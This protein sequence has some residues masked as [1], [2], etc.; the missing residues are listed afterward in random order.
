MKR[1]EPGKRMGWKMGWKP[2]SHWLILLLFTDLFFVFQAWL[3]RPEAFKSTVIMIVLFTVLI[4]LAGVLIDRRRQERQIRALRS[5]LSQPR[6]E[7][8][9]RLLEATD[10]SWHPVIKLVAAQIREQGRMI[11]DKQGELQNYREFIEAW[12]HEIKTPLSLATLVLNNRREEMSPYVHKRMEHVR[13]TISSYVDRILYY[14]RLQSDHADYKF[15]Q[16]DL[17]AFV[18][19]ALEDFRPIADEKN[20]DVQLELPPLQVISDKKVL[21]FMLAQLFSNAFKYTAFDHGM[22]RVVCWRDGEDDSSIH[23]AIRDNGQGVP[24][25][26]R[27]FIFDK[28]FTGSRP[29]RQN[30]TG[31]GL[32]LVKQYG[33]ALAVEVAIESA[34]VSGQG[35]GIELIFPEVV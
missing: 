19:E 7:T 14:A 32:Y 5:F 34:S 27:P 13:Y 16:V 15:E 17:N 9:Q 35:F 11:E 8:E 12:A 20:I 31:M 29:D 10:Q 23:L 6:E 24:P 4:V 25:E 30:A 22:V 21:G 3:T 1:E 2:R 33:E 26:D 18:R 28:G